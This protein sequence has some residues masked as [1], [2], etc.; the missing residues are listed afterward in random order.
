MTSRFTNADPEFSARL[1]AETLPLLRERSRGGLCLQM[2]GVLAFAIADWV[3][4]AEV[5]APLLA[6]AAVQIA[7]A[8]VALVALRGEPTWE[9]TV[10]TLLVDL[11]V[12]FGTGAVSDVISANVFG[13]P[14]MAPV[15]AMIT[16][17]LLPWGAR[18]QIGGVLVT[19]APALAALVV[20][21][22]S[23]A[24]VGHL[25]AGGGCALVASVL[26]ARSF[27]RGRAERK[28][29]NDALAAS[30]A[31]AE[32]EAEI[33]ALLLEVGQTLGARLRQPDML[34]AVNRLARAALGCDWS[35]TFVWDAE[36]H[37]ARLVANAGSSAEL[38]AELAS[39][40]WTLDSVPV[41]HADRPGSLLEIA[42]GHTQGLVPFE[43]MQRMGTASALYAPITVGER[44]LGTQIHGYRTRAG[45]FSTTRILAGPLTNAR[46]GRCSSSKSMFQA[47]H[48]RGLS[49]D[50]ARRIGADKSSR[51]ICLSKMLDTS[52]FRSILIR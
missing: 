23:V 21:R 51:L 4:H 34:E 3:I 25:V 5:F 16:A 49:V 14:C 27:E 42:E 10:G 11:G 33:A 2:A 7:V 13:T 32:E 36:R 29:V 20:I 52:P 24:D 26:V 6:I 37:C 8:V 1:R 50:I 43:L 15:V 47:G 38:V 44:V 22:G 28:R 46:G 17:S 48:C 39:I 12:L 35:S 19:A 31:R 40:E 45:P 9:R 30:K 41:A 18:T